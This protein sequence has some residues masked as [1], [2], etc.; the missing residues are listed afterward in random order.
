MSKPQS[1]NQRKLA[2]K[3]VKAKNSEV[4][5]YQHSDVAQWMWKDVKIEVGN[6]LL[7]GKVTQTCVQTGYVT[8]K[9]LD[10]AEKSIQAGRLIPN[11]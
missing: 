9:L 10:G 5:S 11:F 4:P 7:A 2:I 8:V 6:T 3:M 1:H